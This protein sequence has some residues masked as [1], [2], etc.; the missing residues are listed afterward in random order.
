MIKDNIIKWLK[1]A[2][3][4]IALGISTY[5]ICKIPYRL[6]VL[7]SM[8]PVNEKITLEQI[9]YTVNLWVGVNK[10]D[11]ISIIIDREK[12]KQLVNSPRGALSQYEFD[13]FTT[14]NETFNKLTDRILDAPQSNFNMTLSEPWKLE[15]NENSR[16]RRYLPVKFRNS[17]YVKILDFVLANVNYKRDKG[18][19]YAKFPLETLVEKS[20]DCE[21]MAYLVATLLRNKRKIGIVYEYLKV[22]GQT[23]G[24]VTLAIGRHPNEELP[25]NIFYDDNRYMVVANKLISN[26]EIPENAS[27]IEMYEKPFKHQGVVVKKEMPIVIGYNSDEYF[28]VETT[29]SGYD[30]K[31]SLEK[32]FRFF[33]LK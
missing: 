8:K 5:F 31:K 16:I 32:D 9:P 7:N 28:L 25:Y 17:D 27:F 24:H 6:K 33:P 19:G 22:Q 15:G 10:D 21:D 3:I 4:A 13:Y 14:S 1:R 18:G 23:I 20:G 11:E 26:G 30:I 2:N 12:Y 29:A